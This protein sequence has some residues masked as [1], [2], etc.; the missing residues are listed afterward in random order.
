MQNVCVF[1]FLRLLERWFSFQLHFPTNFQRL[2]AFLWIQNWVH[3]YKMRLCAV[4][5]CSS[6]K[7][8][9]TPGREGD[10]KNTIE[11]KTKKIAQMERHIFTIHTKSRGKNERREFF[12]KV[13]R[14]ATQ[15]S[16]RVSR[17]FFF[18]FFCFIFSVWFLYLKFCRSF[19]S[20]RFRSV[21]FGWTL[22][23]RRKCLSLGVE[24]WW[25]VCV[26]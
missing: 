12:G 10:R 23:W 8:W 9:E 18:F 22:M 7:E 1:R 25:R 13:F 21:S 11:M 14:H 5:R 4:C 2:D 26:Q 3:M 20:I 24:L 15:L 6:V 16:L 17:F 19:H